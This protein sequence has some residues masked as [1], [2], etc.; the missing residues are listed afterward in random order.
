[1]RIFDIYL[2]NEIIE[3]DIDFTKYKLVDAKRFVKTHPAQP[4]IAEEYHYEVIATYSSGGKEI[5][6]VIDVEYVAP[7]ES[8]D[9][10]EDVLKIELLTNEEQLE[11]LRNTREFE[12]FAYINRGKL[13]YDNLT[14][15]QLI[16]LDNWY[17]EWLDVTITKVIPVKPEWLD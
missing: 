1:M 16:E 13:W 5:K 4:E 10:Y 17:K 2:E 9:E 3:N 7:K 11:Y 6:K 12:C 15:Q 14:E 8:Y